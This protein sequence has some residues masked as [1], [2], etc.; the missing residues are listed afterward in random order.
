MYS[1]KK[2]L[3][4]AFLAVATETASQAKA[5]CALWNSTPCVLQLLNMRSRKLMYAKW[6]A[7]Q[8]ESVRVPKA[9]CQPDIE[10]ALAEVLERFGD[11]PLLPWQQANG[12]AARHAL[13]EV[14]AKAYGISE[15]VLA[16]WRVRLANEPTVA[17]LSP[18]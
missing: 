18:M 7:G 10:S 5:L 15:S 13:D 8:L 2:T 9:L 6:A 11:E 3:G 17:N 4:N 1:R 14:A 12:D 16:D